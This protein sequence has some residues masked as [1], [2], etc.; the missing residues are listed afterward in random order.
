[1]FSRSKTIKSNKSGIDMVF[2]LTV[3]VLFVCCLL[4]SVLAFASVYKRLGN[5]IGKRFDTATA[6]TLVLQKLRSYDDADI[7]VGKSGDIAYLG[8]TDMIDG[9]KYITYIYAYGGELK[10]LFVPYDA[11]FNAD[12]G[13]TLLPAAMT[14]KSVVSMVKTVKKGD[15]VSYGRTF[16]AEKD[17]STICFTITYDGVLTSSHYSLRGGKAVGV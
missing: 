6:Q 10:E 11:P 14:V 1:M 4:A 2:V 16:T 8:F 9:D 15:T 5:D 3:F 13:N 12:G 7:S 17:G